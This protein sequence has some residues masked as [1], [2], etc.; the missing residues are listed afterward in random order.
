MDSVVPPLPMSVA[1]FMTALLDRG[2]GEQE[3]DAAIA[4]RALLS[5][6]A[7]LLRGEPDEPLVDISGEFDQRAMRRQIKHLFGPL[8]KVYRREERTCQIDSSEGGNPEGF[9]W[10]EGATPEGLASSDIFRELLEG[11]GYQHIAIMVWRSGLLDGKEVSV[12]EVAERLG[13]AEAIVT[14]LRS[15]ATQHMQARLFRKAEYRL[16]MYVRK[17]D[18]PS[19]DETPI[20]QLQLTPRVHIALKRAGINT[21]EKLAML[22]TSK[23]EGIRTIGDG[24][25]EE[26][27]VALRTRGI[28]LS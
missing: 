28:E 22:P 21:V 18:H 12:R 15:E 26:I 11:L 23:L 3:I 10:T 25:V 27:R 24:S 19:S 2:V 5:Q 4:D 17:S 7:S 20:E 13:V 9:A 16:R 14:K 6:I 1:Q 8:F